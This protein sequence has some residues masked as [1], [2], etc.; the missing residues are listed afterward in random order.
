[1]AWH[2]GSFVMK[3]TKVISAE[4]IQSAM[5]DCA[6]GWAS[7]CYM[8]FISVKGVSEKETLYGDGCNY[9]LFDSTALKRYAVGSPDGCFTDILFSCETVSTSYEDNM[10]ILGN[11][12]LWVFD[13]TE[14]EMMLIYKTK[15]KWY[16]RHWCR[17]PAERIVERSTCI[18]DNRWYK[19]L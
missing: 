5:E 6:Y 15:G 4:E 16:C 2:N 3:P 10:L 19:A 7:D 18:P 8:R 11:Q 1:M 12:R 17:V 9:Y 13:L 14:N